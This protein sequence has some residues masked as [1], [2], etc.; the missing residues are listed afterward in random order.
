MMQKS[1]GFKSVSF[2]AEFM[3]IKIL[4]YSVGVYSQLDNCTG[5]WYI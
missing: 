5:T 2:N 4:F 3:I 1:S